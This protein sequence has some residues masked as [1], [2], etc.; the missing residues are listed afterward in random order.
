MNE[1]WLTELEERLGYKFQNTKLITE[2][3]THKSSKH[4][5][6]NEDWSF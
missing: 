1:N 3:L 2:A 5:K 4:G 6:N